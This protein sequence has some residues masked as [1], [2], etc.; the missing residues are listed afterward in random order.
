MQNIIPDTIGVV[1]VVL[2]L[3]AY[4]LLQVGKIASVSFSY[5]F[6]NLIAAS[7]ILFSLFFDWNLPSVIIEG[8]WVLISAYGI[9][10]YFSLK[11]TTGNS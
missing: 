6:L 1:G 9:Y 2:M 7:M 3:A 10:K 4:F 5:S 8:C 11:R